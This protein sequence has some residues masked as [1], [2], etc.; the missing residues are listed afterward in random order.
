M[1]ACQGCR[2]TGRAG[3]GNDH[4]GAGHQGDFMSVALGT[5]TTTARQARWVMLGI[6]LIALIANGAFRVIGL[7]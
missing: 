2:S 5:G 7:W 4:P 6:L 3:T 1:V